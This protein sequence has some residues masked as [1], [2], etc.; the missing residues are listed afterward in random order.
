MT[1]TEYRVKYPDCRYCK[2]RT[3]D[4]MCK[5]TEKRMSKRTAQKCPCYVASEWGFEK[6]E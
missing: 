5:A 1:V 6:R 4:Y 2:H 3:G